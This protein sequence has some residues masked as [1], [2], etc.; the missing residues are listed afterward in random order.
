MKNIFS[1]KFGVPLPE[2]EKISKLIDTLGDYAIKSVRAYLEEDLKDT[3][4]APCL[5][6]WDVFMWFELVQ[7]SALIDFLISGTYEAKLLVKSLQ[8]CVEW[9]GQTEIEESRS[10]LK[11]MS[12]IN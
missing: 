10:R 12:I 7:D 4:H 9:Y 11:V 6:S 8:S 5:A 2:V 1:A 3:Y